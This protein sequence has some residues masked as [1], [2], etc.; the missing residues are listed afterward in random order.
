MSGKGEIKAAGCLVYRH[1][2]DGLEVLLAHRPLYD[3][4]DF[5][6]GKLE[7]GETELECAIRETEEETG[8]TGKVGAELP[9]DHYM[10]RG[11]DKS[12]RWWLMHQQ[13]GEFVAN[14][15]VD[16]IAWLTPAAAADRLS[17]EHPKQLL[18]YLPD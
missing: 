17:Y 6:K 11:R 9:T 14:E 12:V 4:W 2:Q 16:R 18:A 7:S 3:D 10:V 5:P 8:Y 13:G 1:G 15:E